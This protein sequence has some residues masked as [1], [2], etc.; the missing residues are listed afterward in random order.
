M[1]SDA[2]SF[3]AAA[4]N[5]APVSF[6]RLPIAEVRR[7]FA[8]LKCVFH[9]FVELHDVFDCATSGVV[10]LR[11]YRPTGDRPLPV[12]VYFHGGGWVMGDLDTHDTLCRHLALAA[13]AV[14]VAVD[15]RL[16]PENPFPAAFDDAL[17]AVQFIVGAAGLWGVDPS[18]LAVAGD[19]AGGNLAAAVCLHVRNHGGPSI[20]CQCLIYPVLDPRCDTVSYEVFAERHGL[21]REKMRFFWSSY[22]GDRMEVPWQAAPALAPDLAGLPPTVM[23][24]AEF[25]VL[26]D[27][28]VLF[29]KRLAASGVP[30]ETMN[31]EGVIHGFVHYAGAIRRGRTVLREVGEKL[32]RHLGRTGS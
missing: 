27:E 17:A 24:T 9:P 14:V 13:R 28:G 20:V 15:Y 5:P 26:R 21:T 2:A 31:C 3:L 6:D 16:A 30:V 29:G 22:L 23:V 4:N 12:I 32:Q 25:D 8:S 10:P 7:Q 1:D 18:R 11:V 19:S